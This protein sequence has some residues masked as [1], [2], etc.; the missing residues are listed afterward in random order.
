MLNPYAAPKSQVDDLSAPAQARPA[1]FP[2]GCLKLATMTLVTFGIYEMYWFYQ[3]WKSVQRLTGE[4]LNAPVRAFF[5]PVT[6][7]SMFRRIQEQ[8]RRLQVDVGIRAGA[9]AISVFGLT[10]LW[11][12]P[13]PYWL[14]SLLTFLPLLSVQSEV[15]KINRRVAPDADRNERL[16]AWNVVAVVVGGLIWALAIVGAF[17]G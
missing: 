6:S 10:V 9:L 11:R 16:R 17:S 15:N 14:V 4:K 1:F 8:G 12:L 13:D 7:Y 3:N 5:Y 2:V